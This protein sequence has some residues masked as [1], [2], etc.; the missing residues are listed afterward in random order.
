MSPL[1]DL[2]GN[3][4]YFCKMLISTGEK[5]S[6]V[7]VRRYCRAIFERAMKPAAFRQNPPAMS[8]IS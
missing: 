8:P 5:F 1:V 6:N 3:H 4:R 2:F 7:P